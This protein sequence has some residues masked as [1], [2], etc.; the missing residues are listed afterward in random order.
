MWALLLACGGGDPSDP[1]TG[2]T[3]GTSDVGG[4]PC[5]G[6]ESV[7]TFETSDGVTLEADDMM[8]SETGRPALVLFHMIPPFFDRTSWPK[9][10]RNKFYELDI[11]VL[12]V[13]R[14][15]TG[16]SGGVPEDAYFGDGALWD[17]EAAVSWLVSDDRGCA[18]DPD[19]LIMFGA[20]N[21]T[22]TTL[23][24]TF[25]HAGDL[26]DVAGLAWLSPGDYT[27]AQN[28][29][30]DKRKKLENVSMRWLYP[31]NEPYADDFVDGA[32]DTWQ[33]SRRGMQ[34][35]TDM[36]DEDTLEDDT[37]ADLLALVDEV[38]D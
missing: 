9:R 32:P 28:D 18:I 4:E 38:I 23:D 25:G 5:A 3:A 19:R 13:D 26:P 36:F 33:F 22:T 6:D 8:A 17:A 31:E 7:V 16:G 35:G 11:H 29:I 37:V 12:N 27:E 20:S 1:T 34:H 24:Y 21:G 2:T 10:I 30:D 14:R 15:G